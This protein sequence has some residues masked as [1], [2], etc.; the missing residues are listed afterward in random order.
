M[1]SEPGSRTDRPFLQRLCIAGMNLLI[2]LHTALLAAYF[3]ARELS[4]G[5]F[6]F[7]R[8]MSYGLPWLFS[9]LILFLP[10]AILRRSR[11]LI[12]LTTLS[13]ACFIAVYG[14][15]YLPGLPVQVN[16]PSMRVMTYNVLF[17]NQYADQA[18][19]VIEAHDPDILG[20]HELEPAMAA[21]LEGRFQE[22][23][24]YRE[25]NPGVGLF[26]RYP[27]LQ[28]EVLYFG[29]NDERLGIWG[30]QLLLEVN[31]Q[32]MNVFNVH[33]RVPYLGG[34][35][36][37]GLPLGLPTGFITLGFEQ[38]VEDLLRR[39]DLAIGPTVVIGDLNFTDL[40]GEYALL[41][42][43]LQD[44][45][46]QSGWGMGFT[47]SRFPRLNLALWRIDY[48]LYSSDFDCVRATTGDFGGSDHRPVIA[49]LAWRVDR[50]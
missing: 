35:H 43:N 32:R 30:Q 10:S 14:E 40:E 41:T 12:T 6:W 18:A 19:T 28:S 26:S 15:L 50:K 45:H 20:L 38:D 7:V 39:M 11:L 9:P 4:Q 37:F 42:Q 36:P 46:R 29:Q 47:F 27:I 21:S 33:P 1:S 23:Y 48:I 3:I 25:I 24:P 44:A 16:A 17:N 2:P 31:G 34:V 49:E 22:R 13:A 8:M 5:K